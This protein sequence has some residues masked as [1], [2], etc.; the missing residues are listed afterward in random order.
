MPPIPVS[1][2]RLCGLA[3]LAW[4]TAT[5]S[6]L[7]HSG[8]ATGFASLT[9]RGD[10]VS[11]RL[12]PSG[13][14]GSAADLLREKITMSADGH[15]CEVTDAAGWDV[16][17]RCPAAPHSLRIRDDLADALGERHHV[18]GMAT[19]SGGSQSFDLSAN[20][21]EATLS[22]AATA[23]GQAQGAGSFFLLG[24]EHIA[25]GYDHLLF[26]LALVL[27]GGGLI[28]LLKIITAFTVAHSLTLGAA[29]LDLLTLPSTLVEAVIAL[30]IAY[31]A[32][33]NLVPKYAL[34]RRWL[35]S[36]LFG[37]VHGFGFSSV[38]K[39]IGLPKGSELMALLN[40][41]LGVEAGQVV[42][43]L[44]VVPLLAWLK[45][46]RWERLAVRTVSFAVLLVGLA[47]FAE[48]ALLPA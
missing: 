5:G 32:F 17:F 27:C 44:L 22:L 45:A 21:R 33:E 9:I 28:S 36:F 7:A 20:E 10:V 16:S 41:N 3:A 48:R 19:W 13:G 25:T 38:L 24:I 1:A 37:L 42:A 4:F 34:P 18:V 39:E 23:T 29:A 43:V 8:D 30:S 35:I 31:V 12:T 26:V 6:A 2:L 40:F 15:P 14:S 47:L 46:T 11:Y